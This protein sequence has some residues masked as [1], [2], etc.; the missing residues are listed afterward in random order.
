MKGFE[1][2]LKDNNAHEE[3]ASLMR[4]CEKTPY[5]SLSELY[6]KVDTEE[7]VAEAMDWGRKPFLAELDHEWRIICGTKRRFKDEDKGY[8]V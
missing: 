8:Q 2:F 6:R 5:N 4:Q 3:F 7:Y 1:Q